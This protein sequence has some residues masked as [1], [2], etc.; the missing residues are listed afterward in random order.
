MDRQV[1]PRPIQ[2]DRGKSRRLR[3]ALRP[4]NPT[5]RA[6]TSSLQISDLFAFDIAS[7]SL[8]GWLAVASLLAYLAGAIS[9][10][11]RGRSWTVPGT[12]SFVIGCAAWF[13]ATGL[14]VNAHANELITA[15]IFQQLTLLVAAPPLLL[16]GSPGT[17]LLRTVPHRGPGRLVLRAAIA[18]QRSRVARVLLHP[19]VAII[20]AIVAFPGLYFTDA[21]SS[22]LAVPGG[23]QTLLVALLVFGVIGG[24]PL[25]ALDPLPRKPSFSVRLVG[26]FLELQVHALFG[27]VLLRSASGMLSWYSQ[28]P[29]GWG[30]SR[31]LDQSLSGSLVWTYG[32]L[33]LL[34]VLIVTL[35][36]WRKSDMRFARHRRPAEDAALDEY[37]AYLAEV[38]A[39]D[40]RQLNQKGSA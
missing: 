2:Q 14:G 8:L 33:P 15:L 26:A 20:V 38:A 5:S 12:I 9:L 29:E 27:L 35:S 1:A 40:S 34:I 28:E 31:A 17:L 3:K 16:M 13:V 11:V 6:L 23:H 10:W 39:Q 18:A 21:V 19:S 4:V 32:Q 22:V 25:W 30:I 37:N 36:K 24:A 7:V